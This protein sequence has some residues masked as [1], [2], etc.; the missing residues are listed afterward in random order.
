M[1]VGA[2]VA[3]LSVD[4]QARSEGVRAELALPFPILCDSARTVVRGWDLYHAKEMG[5][6]AIPGVFVVGPDLRVRYRS[7]DDTAKRVS[8][9]G[10]LRFLRGEAPEVE[11]ARERVRVGI[12]DFVRAIRN[13]IRRGLRTPDA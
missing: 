9:E 13:A 12:G 4:S 1:A 10:V 2:D 5:G 11:I 6:I 3:A 8:T 7:I